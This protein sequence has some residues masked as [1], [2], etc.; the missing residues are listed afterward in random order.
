[1]ASSAA[2]G[3]FQASSFDHMLHRA[4]VQGLSQAEGRAL[5]WLLDDG[6][7]A[8]ADTWATVSPG[9]RPRVEVREPVGF[10][11]EAP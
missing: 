4:R 11:A 10:D 3:P 5:E 6:E 8:P 2:V 1:M 9:L 7:F